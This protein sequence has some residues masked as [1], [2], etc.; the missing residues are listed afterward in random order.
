MSESVTD[1]LHRA[2]AGDGEAE[3]SLIRQVYPDLHAMASAQFRRERRQLTLQP[4]ALVNEV[5]LK[6][7]GESSA[8]WKNRAHFF[9]IAARAMRQILTDHARRVCSQKR[10]SGVFHLP[11]DEGLAVTEERFPDILALEEGLAELEKVNPRLVKVVVSRFY[12]D[13]TEDEIAESLGVSSRTIKRDWEFARA[14]L[15]EWLSR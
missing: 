11:L 14:W 2:S 3:A 4:T 7:M 6:L 1:L 5:Y 9:A 12:G 8:K 10:G 13:L 15:E